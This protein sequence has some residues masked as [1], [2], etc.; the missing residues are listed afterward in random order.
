MKLPRRAAQ[1]VEKVG[2]RAVTGEP[3][4]ADTDPISKG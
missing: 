4:V 2:L 3:E 1:R